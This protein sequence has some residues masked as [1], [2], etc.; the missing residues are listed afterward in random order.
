MMAK[1]KDLD[2]NTTGTGA[3]IQ[4]GEGMGYFGKSKKKRKKTRSGYMGYSE[5][6]NEQEEESEEEP[7]EELEKDVEKISDLPVLDKVNTKPEWED[8]MQVAWDMA[9]DIKTVNDSHKK[10]WLRTALKSFNKI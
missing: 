6:V 3:S 7:E 2:E 5:P 1:E 10:S 4:A 8:M 9:D